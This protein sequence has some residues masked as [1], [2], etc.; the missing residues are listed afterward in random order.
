M[1]ILVRL[2][3]GKSVAQQHREAEERDLRTRED[4]EYHKARRAERIK[5]SQERGRASARRPSLKGRVAGGIVSGL[6]AGAERQRRTTRRPTARRTQRK[7]VYIRERATR[8]R[9]GKRRPQRPWSPGDNPY[10]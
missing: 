2:R 9:P 10:L 1:G 6:L 5:V 3:G 8:Q 7:I 4:I